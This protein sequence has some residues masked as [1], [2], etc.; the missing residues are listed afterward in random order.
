MP[1]G[2]EHCPVAL[3]AACSTACWS[4][5]RHHAPRH[6]GSAAPSLG[7]L[8]RTASGAVRLTAPELPRR[9]RAQS[10]LI[11][12]RDRRPRGAA[13]RRDGAAA[14]AGRRRPPSRSPP[15]STPR[16]G[17]GR[18]RGPRAPSSQP[19]R[20][21]RGP[22]RR[23]R[24]DEARTCC[25]SSGVSVVRVGD[26]HRAVVSHGVESVGVDVEHHAVDH[27]RR[28]PASARDVPVRRSICTVVS[29]CRGRRAGAGLWSRW[30]R[31]RR[32]SG[33]AERT[34]GAQRAD[35]II[36]RRASGECAAEAVKG[37]HPFPSGRVDVRIFTGRAAPR[38]CCRRRRVPPPSAAAMVPRESSRP[39]SAAAPRSKIPHRGRNVAGAAAS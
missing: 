8:R 16:R 20:G 22:P 26:A 28:A 25:E 15:P 21:A 4:S 14:A 24:R 30:Q 2:V 11:F 18:T 1:K 39:V 13:A 31:A 35:R 29:R 37:A 7:V 5:A 38:R 32:R 27:T 17:R 36:P 19:R 6:T 34:P 33:R 12:A 10:V 9:R 23:G 3:S